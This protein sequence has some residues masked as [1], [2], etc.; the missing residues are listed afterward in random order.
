MG[1]SVGGFVTMYN[2]IPKFLIVFDS[3]H[4]FLR[5]D[6]LAETSEH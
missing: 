6:Y 5:D 4:H 1:L 3:A 2:K